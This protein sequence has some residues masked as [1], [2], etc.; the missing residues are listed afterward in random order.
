MWVTGRVD[1]SIWVRQQY[2]APS[3]DDAQMQLLFECCVVVCWVGYCVHCSVH[4]SISTQM[5]SV[6][7]PPSSNICIYQRTV[8]GVH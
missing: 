3:L 8:Q 5:F 2:R 7:P 1:F 6:C 4:W